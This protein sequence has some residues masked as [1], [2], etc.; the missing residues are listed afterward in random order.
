[1]GGRDSMRAWRGWIAGAAAALA[2]CIAVG[3]GAAGG[4]SNVKAGGTYRVAFESAFGFT[5]GFDPTGEYYTF[6]WA[7]E[8]NL[9][10]RTLVGYNHV[11]GPAGNVLV[12]DIATSVPKPTDGGTTYT[13]HLKHGVKFGPPLNRQVT[14]ADVL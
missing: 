14:S 4:Q 13:F 3:G 10:I 12:P 5:D 8:S 11:A 7:I 1:M 9:M 6:S 2:A